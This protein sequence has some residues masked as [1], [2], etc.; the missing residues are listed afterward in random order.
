MEGH[1][2]GLIFQIPY[3]AANPDDRDDARRLRARL[4]EIQAARPDL[5][6]SLEDGGA[7][8]RFVMLLLHVRPEDARRLASALV[9]SC[10]EAGWGT[11]K[12]LIDEHFPDVRAKLLSGEG[13]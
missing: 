9:R 7:A 1:D 2:G 3:D 11:G 4:G 6:C 5:P 13:V 12:P 8:G 10:G